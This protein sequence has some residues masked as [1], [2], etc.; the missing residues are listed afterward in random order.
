MNRNSVVRVSTKINSMLKISIDDITKAIQKDVHEE[1]QRQAVENF[2][3]FL[4]EV[5]SADPNT[6][7]GLMKKGNW[8]FSHLQTIQK[9]IDARNLR[10]VLKKEFSL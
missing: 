7:R 2:C 10:D 3:E 4:G 6:V 1:M 5:I 9:R 8:S